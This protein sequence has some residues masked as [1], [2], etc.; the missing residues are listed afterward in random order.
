MERFALT[1]HKNGVEPG[2]MRNGKYSRKKQIFMN[3]PIFAAGVLFWLVVVTTYLAA[4]LFAKY[5]TSGT[6]TDS[7]KIMAFGKLTVTDS[8]PLANQEDKYVFLPGVDLKKKITVAF[9]GSNAECFVFVKAETTGWIPDDTH[10][11]FMDEPKR[12]TWSV[13]NDWTYLCSDANYHVYYRPLAANEELKATSFITG[14]VITVYNIVANEKL[15]TRAVYESDPQQL[16]INVTAYA[17][18]ANGFVGET[19]P[20][21]ALAAWTAVR[22]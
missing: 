18:Q 16:N 22:N 13:S 2:D 10:K 14:D 15:D 8:N 3:I 7:A 19:E 12:L 21:R 6:T 20:V 17:V 5:T 1:L 9:T 4:G 11:V